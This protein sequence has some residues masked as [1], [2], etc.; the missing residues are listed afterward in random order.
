MP[1][2]SAQGPIIGP[3]ATSIVQSTSPPAITPGTRMRDT[4]GNEYLFVDFVGPVFGGVPVEIFDDNTAQQL[5]VTGRARVGVACGQATSNDF[6]WVQIY[7]R[8][9]VQLGMSGVSPS[10]AA[11]GPT[12]LQ[13]VAGMTIFVLGTSLTSPNGVGWVSGNAGITSASDFL[14]ENMWVATDAS[15]ADVSA[16]TS[17]TSHTGG[18]IAVFLNFP[19]IRMVDYVSTS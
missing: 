1:E 12:T 3:F 18:Q 15:P 9:Q 2:L 10:D 17:A 14:I 6:G 11:N 5:G 7:G 13:T 19:R 4:A 16:V 8:C